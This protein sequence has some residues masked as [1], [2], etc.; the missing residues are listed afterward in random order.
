[1]RRKRFEVR[2]ASEEVRSGLDLLLHSSFFV[3]TSNFE[4]LPIEPS[5]GEDAAVPRFAT[6]I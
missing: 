4:P 2:G 5:G 1:L 3:R 6:L